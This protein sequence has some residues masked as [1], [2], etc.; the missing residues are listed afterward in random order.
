MI[1][2]KIHSKERIA[3]ATCVRHVILVILIVSKGIL[4]T[5][6]FRVIRRY[7]LVAT[8]Q[9]FIF[10]FWAHW[11]EVTDSKFAI[12]INSSPRLKPTDSDIRI[13][14]GCYTFLL[15]EIQ[16]AVRK[17]GTLCPPNSCR[18]PIAARKKTSAILFHGM[19]QHHVANADEARSE[20]SVSAQ[21]FRYLSNEKL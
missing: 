4:Q 3:I 10:F 7:R 16:A 21:T 8:L 17:V 13:A 2:I 12:H 20:Y 19:H 1:L 14:S 5:A 15:I 11:Q 6:T 9:D 18:I